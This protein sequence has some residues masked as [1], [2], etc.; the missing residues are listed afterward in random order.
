MKAKLVLQ[1]ELVVNL[2]AAPGYGPHEVS[3]VMV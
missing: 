2:D 3:Y 1:A